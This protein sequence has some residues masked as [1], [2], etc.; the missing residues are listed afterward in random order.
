[1]EDYDEDLSSFSGAG[2]TPGSSNTRDFGYGGGDEVP[3]DSITAECGY[4]NGSG[5]FFGIFGTGNGDGSS[6]G[7]GEMF[8]EWDECLYDVIY[9][10]HVHYFFGNG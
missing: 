6:S 7:K 3:L 10:G 9:D 2:Y 4:G 8:Q 5:C 1:M